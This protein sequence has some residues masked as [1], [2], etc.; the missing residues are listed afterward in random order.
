[1]IDLGDAMVG[2]REYDLLGP[3]LFLAAG[4]GALLR[5][6]FAH[7]RGPH[8]PLGPEVRRGLVALF[9]LHRYSK[10]DVQLRLSGWRDRARTLDELGQL[11]WPA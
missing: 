8:W 6:L 11:I 3:S 1:M 5:T 2:P 9:V 10:P 7:A 4:D